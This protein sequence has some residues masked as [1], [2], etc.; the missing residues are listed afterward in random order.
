M[1]S[2][3]LM[4]AVSDCLVFDSMTVPPFVYLSVDGHLGCF[5]FRI[6]MT[7]AAVNTLVQVFCGFM[8]SF[9]LDKYLGV[10]FVGHRADINLAL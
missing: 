1:L 2:Q 9:R 3:A 7:M 5:Q 8:F 4:L 6:I 10:E